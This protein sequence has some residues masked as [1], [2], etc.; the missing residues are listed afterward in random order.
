MLES[1]FVPQRTTIARSRAWVAVLL[2]VLALP[3]C[4]VRKMAINSL[5]NALAEGGSSY[6]TDDDPQ[7]VREAVPF[8]L[9]TIEGLLE[10]APR[11]RGLLYAA[12]SGFTQY[13]FAFLQQEA[14]LGEEE[15][16][17]R[18]TALRR[19]SLALYRRA[20]EYGL[21]GLEVDFP[22]VREALRRDPAAALARTRRRHVPLLFWTANAW[23]A[24]ISLAKSDSDLT[25]DMDLAAALMRRSL[26]L[27][28]GYEHGSGH[29]FFISYEGGRASIG[30]SLDEARTHLERSLTLS[31]GQRAW[32]LV[33]YAET[34]SVARQDRQEFEKLLGDALALDVSR[35]RELRLANVVAQQRA[36][37][38]LG[39]AD[40]LFE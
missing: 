1:P 27:D 39:R 21:R 7:L 2:L 8:G 24:A 19:R 9:K 13:A 28:E 26:E 4:S 3:G 10:E 18:S 32:A 25:K 30:G 33:T 15:S 38:L 34:V 23:G 40:E 22:G 6:A 35:V 20:L 12:A 36:R 16:F 31:R 5:G 37:W 11:H 14:D 29:D 17:Q